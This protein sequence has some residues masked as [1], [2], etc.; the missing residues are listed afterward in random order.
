MNTMKSDFFDTMMMDLLELD[1]F[2]RMP[3][4][5]MVLPPPDTHR[6]LPPS[7]EQIKEK[8]KEYRAYPLLL[9]NYQEKCYAAF[10]KWNRTCLEQMTNT[11]LNHLAWLFEKFHTDSLKLMDEESGACFTAQNFYFDQD[12]NLVLTNPR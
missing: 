4:D 8:G 2:T 10:V 7:E 5:E 12:K 6:P 11:D 3:Y 9:E 1:G